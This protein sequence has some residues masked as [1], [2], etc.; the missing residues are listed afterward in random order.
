MADDAPVCELFA[1]GGWCDREAGTCPELHVWECGEWRA[2]GVCS[3]GGKCGLRHVLRAEQGKGSEQEAAKDGLNGE[4][5][6]FADTK[7]VKV[8]VEGAFEEQDEFIVF[9]HGTPADPESDPESEDE[10]SASGS[11]SD[12]DMGDEDEGDGK[13]DIAATPI[14]KPPRLSAADSSSSE[15]EDESEDEVLGIVM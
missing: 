9:D 8:P 14:G 11:G 12:V 6:M 5:E 10:G 7:G 15:S 13:S 1:R 4:Q 3:K 2:K